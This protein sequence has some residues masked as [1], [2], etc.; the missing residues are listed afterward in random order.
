MA[1]E[2][3]ILPM[4]PATLDIGRIT[5]YMGKASSTMI[6]DLTTV[7]STRTTRNTAKAN[8]Y[9]Q[10]EINTKELLSLTFVMGLGEWYD[11]FY[12]YQPY[13]V[14]PVTPSLDT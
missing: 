6:L 9:G 11:A 10:M 7:G 13:D 2:R 14:R 12:M 3:T 8:L 5:T 1:E 4:G